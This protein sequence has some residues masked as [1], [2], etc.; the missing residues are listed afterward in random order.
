M[1]RIFLN[2]TFLGLAFAAAG[3]LLAPSGSGAILDSQGSPG[4]ES[5]R[6]IL[7]GYYQSLGMEPAAARERAAALGDDEVLTLVSSL[8]RASVGGNAEGGEVDPW[9]VA[10]VI[11]VVLA[12][13]TGV[14]FFVNN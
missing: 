1:R 7:A 10:L 14:Y 5:P 9:R 4:A 11:A 8:N 2:R 13:F 6:Q 3:I 12:V